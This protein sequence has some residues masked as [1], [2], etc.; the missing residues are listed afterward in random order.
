MIMTMPSLRRLLVTTSL[1]AGLLAG[2]G[3]AQAGSDTE[4][5][6]ATCAGCHG[7]DGTSTGLATPTIA[8]LPVDYFVDAMGAYK[9]DAKPSTV[10][11]R[12]AKGYSDEEI[13]AMAR[14]FLAK[15]F[16]RPEQKTDLAK[17]EAGKA[18]AAKYCGTCHEDEGRVAEGVGVLA[19]QKL[20]YMK[21]SVAD[22]LSGDREMEKRQKQKF[23]ALLAEQGRDA[24]DAVLHYYASRQ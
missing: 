9:K 15:P 3:I 13:Q 5:M 4:V 20:T 18:L 8:G 14:H 2:A 1:V 6:T 10:M 21:Y 24:F 16:G 17:V 7:V 12:I 19:G 22:F 11:A 23:D